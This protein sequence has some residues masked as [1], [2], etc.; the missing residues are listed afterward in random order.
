MK[1]EGE[2]LENGFS[3]RFKEFMAAFNL[4]IN[5]L[6]VQMSDTDNETLIQ[7]SRVKYRR[8]VNGE[9]APAYEGLI[10]IAKKYGLS[11]DWLLLGEGQM[12]RLTN[13]G[14]RTERNVDYKELYESERQETKRLS[15]VN[16][17]LSM[18]IL[19]KAGL[20]VNQPDIKIESGSQ[21][22]ANLMGHV[23]GKPLRLKGMDD[24]RM[25]RTM[26]IPPIGRG[27]PCRL[28]KVAGYLSDGP[29]AQSVADVSR[30]RIRQ[31]VS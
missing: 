7:G 26:I 3:M 23:N 25:D 6:A 15:R 5:R 17:R 20:L 8:W 14:V 9:V 28:G 1:K 31:G 24:P 21:V 18:S 11:M 22:T 29:G 2:V 12:L 27:W 4:N 30:F 13:A 16:E 10:K 19:E